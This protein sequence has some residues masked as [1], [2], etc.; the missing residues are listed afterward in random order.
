MFAYPRL[1]ATYLV[2][3][4]VGSRVLAT[5]KHH[6]QSECITALTIQATVLYISPALITL[7]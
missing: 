7:E 3:Y 2:W 1:E 6:L 5:C 4:L